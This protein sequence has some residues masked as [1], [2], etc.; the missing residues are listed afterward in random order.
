MKLHKGTGYVDDLR[1]WLDKLRLGSKIVGGKLEWTK[2]W[3]EADQA[4]NVTKKTLTASVVKEIMNTIS[5][6]IK[7]TVELEED[8]SQGYLPTLDTQLKMTWMELEDG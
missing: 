2:E 8:F 6:D 5:P 7:M 3:E 4:S 1:F